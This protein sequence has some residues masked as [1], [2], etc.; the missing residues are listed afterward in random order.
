MPKP[1]VLHLGDPIAYN[2]D[3]YNGPFSERFTIIRNE[4]L[5]RE[6]FI[7][8][9]KTNKYGPI[10]ALLRPHF[11]SGNEMSPWDTT[12]ISYLPPST[13]IFSSAGA[14]YDTISIPSLTTKGIYYTNGAG[15][16]DEAV[17]DTTIYMILSV[18]RNF[19][20]SQMAARSGDTA[21]F[22]AC[23]KDLA[24]ISHNPRGKVLGLIGLGRIG[25][26]VARKARM[27]LGMEVVYFDSKRRVEEWERELGVVWGGG[28]KGTMG[29][30]DVVS[31]HCDLNPE[32]KGLIDRERI[33]WMK[34]GVRVVNVARGGVVV[35]GDL[36]DALQTGK[37]S[38]AALDVHEFEPVVDERLRGMENV[39]LTTHVGGG[40]VETRMG[41]ERLA[42]ENILAV[43]G[44]D[45]EV[46]GEPLT[47]VNGREV[48]EVLEGRKNGERE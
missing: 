8:A 15:A 41:F 20:A 36:V 42:M 9:L 26:L 12:L 6:S 5:T 34:D 7:E 29:R 23:H 21:R 39:T 37:V 35:E 30:A 24:G 14:G 44:E 19:T 45:G 2:H 3:L 16:S 10:S 28:L 48:R 33:G 27:G 40:V 47:A 13:K 1:I 4:D 11:A 17:S 31:V 32:T 22:M 38:A 43:V 18:F 46:R 25:A